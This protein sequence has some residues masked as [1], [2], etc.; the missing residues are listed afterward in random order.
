MTSCASSGREQNAD[1]ESAGNSNSEV[2]TAVS[3]DMAELTVWAILSPEIDDY[4]TNY[5]SKWYE[6]YSGVKI[7]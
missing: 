6:E 5:Q 1:A 7:H 3:D 4:A 2:A